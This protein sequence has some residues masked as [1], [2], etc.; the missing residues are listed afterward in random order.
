MTQCQETDAAA[1]VQLSSRLCVLCY[2]SELEDPAGGKSPS[3]RTSP[4][5]EPL[6]W[7][8]AA[9]QAGGGVPVRVSRWDFVVIDSCTLLLTGG[10]A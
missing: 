2:R 6:R 9:L 10:Y 8:S 5:E 3:L 7:T 4:A 1:D